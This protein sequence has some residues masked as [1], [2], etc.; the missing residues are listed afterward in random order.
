MADREENSTVSRADAELL[1]EVVRARFLNLKP[2]ESNAI[3]LALQ[4]LEWLLGYDS[5]V[6]RDSLDREHAYWEANS[7]MARRG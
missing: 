4:G 6:S 3:V 7:I 1:F 2:D 5:S